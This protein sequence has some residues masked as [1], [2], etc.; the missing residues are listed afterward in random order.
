MPSAERWRETLLPHAATMLDVAGRSIRNGLVAG[1][2]LDVAAGRFDAPLRTHAAS[3]VSLHL[4][5]GSLRGC[6]GSVAAA[7]PLVEDITR[8]AYLAAFEDPRF[9]PLSAEAYPRL[10]IEI[11]VLSPPEP[12]PFADEAALCAALVPG[13][14]GLL[15]EQGRRRGLFLPQVWES[16][17]DPVEFVGHLKDKA[18]LP[19]G[20]LDGG[21]RASRFTVVSFSAA[22]ASLESPAAR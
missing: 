17:P 12:L 2:A 20:P 1:R 15:L 21:V 22:T 11:S 4:L 5:D 3:F 19:P 16:L 18:A 7:R 10:T 9:P 14:D 8:N 6:I 13:R